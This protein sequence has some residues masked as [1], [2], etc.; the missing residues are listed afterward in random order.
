MS[1]IVQTATIPG[2]GSQVVTVDPDTGDIDYVVVTRA[3]TPDGPRYYQEGALDATTA[4]YNTTVAS[5]IAHH[6][7]A[8]RAAGY[9]FPGDALA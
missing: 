8:L 1:N 7:T 9:S 3:D 6:V 5:I 4:D 2:F